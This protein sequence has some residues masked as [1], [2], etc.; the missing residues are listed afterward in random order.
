MSRRSTAITRARSLY[1]IT[2]DW[3]LYRISNFASGWDEAESLAWRE[4]WLVTP[5]RNDICPDCAR[6]GRS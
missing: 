4:G 3:C 1:D 2:C 5:G 6:R